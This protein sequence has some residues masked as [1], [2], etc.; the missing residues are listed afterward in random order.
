MIYLT[1]GGFWSGLSFTISSLLGFGL[2]L[3][4]ANFL[5]KEN[6]GVYKYIFSVYGLL[7][8]VSF[9]SLDVLIVRAVSRGY[10]G[11]LKKAFTYSLKW[12]VPYLFASLGVAIYYYLNINYPL[13]VAFCFIAILAPITTSYNV[14]SS[15]LN[16]KKDFRLISISNSV[17]SIVSAITTFFII[18]Y[19][20]N[21]IIV[22]M[23]YF[24]THVITAAFYYSWTIKKYRPNDRF[25]EGSLSLG[26]HYSLMNVFTIV[27]QNIDK[28]IIFH[29]LGGASLAIYSFALAPVGQ[30]QGLLKLFGPVYSP[31]ILAQSKEDNKKNLPNKFWQIAL[32]MIIPVVG[33]I[34][35]APYFYKIFFPQYI[36]AIIFSQFYALIL[37]T[38]GKKFIGIPTVVHL[39]K[40]KLYTL[41]IINAS[42]VVLPKLILLYFFG[43][44]GAI[45]A[46]IISNILIT[47]VSFYYL[48]T[49]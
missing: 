9:S 36:E 23:G 31:K 20:Q 39:P 41:S 49:M 34:I 47:T 42:I 8:A 13:A 30:I 25:E 7:G 32:I 27:S 29:F 6:Y 45:A 43:L 11:I 24:I 12:N 46:E 15:F 4:F 16:G 17:T 35:V 33:Y 21:P 38:Y 18:I 28:I 48:K 22:V 40:K 1:R 3:V 26:K 14:Y 10:D 5:D 44:A 37:L 19:T 2:T